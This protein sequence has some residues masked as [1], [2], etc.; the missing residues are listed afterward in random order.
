MASPETLFEDA[1]IQL[2]RAL[3][4]QGFRVVRRAPPTHAFGDCLVSYRR[5]SQEVRLIWDVRGHCFLLQQT[6]ATLPPDLT[7]PS[8]TDVVREPFDARQDSADRAA[9]VAATLSLAISAFAA[10][11]AA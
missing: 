3:E 6:G 1:A 11:G 8:W 10:P 4:P 9:E 7:E 5:G 2:A